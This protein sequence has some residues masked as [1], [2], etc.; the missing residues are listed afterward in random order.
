[1]SKLEC[2]YVGTVINTIRQF[3]KVIK[4]TMENKYSIIQ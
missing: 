2:Y 4:E 1:M 3:L